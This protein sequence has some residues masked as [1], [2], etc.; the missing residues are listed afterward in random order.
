MNIVCI[1]LCLV[2][3]LG[4][5][6]LS[7]AHAGNAQNANGNGNYIV[8]NHGS[9]S[10]NISSSEPSPA[11]KNVADSLNKIVRF[12]EASNPTKVQLNNVRLIRWLGEDEFVLTLDL[13]NPSSMPGYKVKT[14]LLAPL[15][16]GET[17]SRTLS[18]KPGRGF[19][20]QLLDTLSV[21]AGGRQSVP[22]ATVS[23]LKRFVN[24]PEKYDL[25]GAGL[26]NNVPDALLREYGNQHRRTDGSAG[27]ASISLSFVAK[28]NYETAF[29]G[30]NQS[31]VSVFL[32]F[33]K[34]DASVQALVFP[35]FPQ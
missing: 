28:T 9:G 11:T 12:L 5:P 22:I 6:M 3:V 7:S 13:D 1:A 2:T 29:G 14:M 4:F 16:R 21:E 27:T 34:P 23:E 26:A 30:K 15:G 18:M 20:R 10:V 25:I 24:F 31:L 35:G 32:Y 19:S 33:A 17:Q 8:N